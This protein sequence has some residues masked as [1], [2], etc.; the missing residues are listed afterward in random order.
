MARLTFTG[1][2]HPYSGKDLS[3]DRKIREVFPFEGKMFFPLKQ[4]IGE[5]AVPVV[6]LGEYVCCGQLIARADGELSA[7]LHSPVSG[8]V[9]AMEDVPDISGEPV[10]SIIIENDGQYV[11]FARRHDID[12][13]RMTRQEILTAI[14]DAGIVGLGGS[15]LPTEYKLLNASRTTMNTIIANCV[16][17]EPYLTSDY[18]RILEDP[19]KVIDGLAI[20]LGVF[21]K[22]KGIIAVSESNREGFQ[23]LRELLIDNP[24]IYVRRCKDKYP[25][26]SERQLIHAVTGRSL[27]ARMLPYE[28]GCLVVNTQTLAAVSDAVLLGEP[29]TKRVI[30]VSGPAAAAPCNLR[31]RLGETYRDVLEQAGNLGR[32]YKEDN[33]LLLAGG[34]ITG[35]EIRNLDAPVTKL[36]SAIICLP[37]SASE[38][39]KETP[40][41]RCR[42][43]VQTCPEQL[44]PMQ[45][46]KDARLRNKPAFA[47]HAGM[48]C[49]DCGCC[50]YVCPAGIDLAAEIG[51]MKRD[52]LR[53]SALAGDYARRYQI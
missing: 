43:C 29:L 48:E 51:A 33:T 39:K 46:I 27:N 24:R 45:L 4:H 35:H 52:C 9:V 1:G 7:N 42:R 26:G 23:L 6:S 38:E 10:P 14:R 19:W 11:P 17:C 49:C 37:K 30:T 40:C 18:R 31:V 53:N 41:I 3:K 32:F 12:P 16:E 21:P 36:S 15:G 8:R 47:E 2:I 5:P 13:T 44:V 22:A 28:I 50:S 20:L 25:Q 34:P